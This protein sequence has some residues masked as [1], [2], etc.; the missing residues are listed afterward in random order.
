[1][2]FPYFKCVCLVKTNVFAFVRQEHEHT[3]YSILYTMHYACVYNTA[4]EVN[5]ETTLDE[6]E[7]FTIT[8]VWVGNI[9][10]ISCCELIPFRTT[11][12]RFCSSDNFVG[13]RKVKLRRYIF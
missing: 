13:V 1:M 5:N 4:T 3:P 8:P 11:T 6:G 7:S 12:K 2:A 10:S 9:I